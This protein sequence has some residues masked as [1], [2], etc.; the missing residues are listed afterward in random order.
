MRKSLDHR[1]AKAFPS[2]MFQVWVEMVQEYAGTRPRAQPVRKMGVRGIQGQD[3]KQLVE[4]GE[5][6]RNGNR[7]CSQDSTTIVLTFVRSC[8]QEL[9]F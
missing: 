4:G 7:I 1:H 3:S 9:G 6:E 8:F 2:F 5:Q